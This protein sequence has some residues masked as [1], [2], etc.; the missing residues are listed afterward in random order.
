[1]FGFKCGSTIIRFVLGFMSTSASETD[2]WMLAKASFLSRLMI[3]SGSLSW[4][5]HGDHGAL[6][7]LGK[8]AE[9]LW[10]SS[11]VGF[12]A[13]TPEHV[14]L[15]ENQPSTWPVEVFNVSAPDTLWI[16]NTV[17]IGGHQTASTLRIF[18]MSCQWPDQ[19]LLIK[20]FDSSFQF[21]SP[22]WKVCCF[23]R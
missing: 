18:E 4:N 15:K 12:S 3:Q 20:G 8:E 10:H 1:M 17:F 5:W 9:H 7:N 23:S 2:V 14:D 21:F 6:D 19:K 13:P 11:E 22:I 16:H